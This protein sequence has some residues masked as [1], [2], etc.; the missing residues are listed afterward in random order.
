MGSDRPRTYAALAL[1]EKARR[2]REAVQFDDP[3]SRADV[4]LNGT[5]NILLR[6]FTGNA[7][8]LIWGFANLDEW[9]AFLAALNRFDKQVRP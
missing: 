7:E 9:G 3:D 5:T 8:P 6:F 1:D 2:P 4:V